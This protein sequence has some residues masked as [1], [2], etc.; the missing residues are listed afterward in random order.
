MGNLID[1]RQV[2]LQMLKRLSWLITKKMLTFCNRDQS[3]S[4]RVIT[5]ETSVNMPLIPDIKWYDTWLFYLELFRSL[6]QQ[7]IR[8]GP[9]GSRKDVLHCCIHI[10]GN[11]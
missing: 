11:N 7:E 5:L 8:V 2:V 6:H 1:F 4:N 9:I 3:L 10:P